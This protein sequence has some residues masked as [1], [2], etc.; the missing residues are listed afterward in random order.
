[1]DL[2]TIQPP[3][4]SPSAQLDLNVQ[5]NAVQ[6]QI[7]RLPV[8]ATLV[9]TV[10]GNDKNGNLIVRMAG[11]DLI[12]SSPLAISKGAQVALKIDNVSGS[13]TA[14]LL[15]I[16]GKL[17]A[18]QPQAISN[19]LQQNPNALLKENTPEA[20]KR[21]FENPTSLKIVGVLNQGTAKIAQPQANV[22]QTNTAVVAKSDIV[23]L[24]SPQTTAVKAIM[25]TATPEIVQGL[26]ASIAMNDTKPAKSELVDSLPEE[27]KP[28]TV[29]N[30]KITKAANPE[31]QVV[32]GDNRA[33][34]GQEWMKEQ[35]KVAGKE[36]ANPNPSTSLNVNLKASAE[37]TKSATPEINTKLAALAAS[38]PDNKQQMANNLQQL[39]Q[40]FA[41]SFKPLPNGNILL[42]AIVIDT[43]PD[44][45]LLVETRF[46]KMIVDAGSQYNNIQKGAVLDLEI[47]SFMQSP[48]AEMKLPE[49]EMT[50]QNL[51]K[52]WPAL[53]ELIEHSQIQQNNTNLPNKLAG[54]DSLFA[55]RMAAFMNAIK[56]G[57]LREWLGRSNYDALEADDIGSTLLGKIK[58]DLGTI[59]DL[60]QNIDASKW[61]TMLFPIY[62]GRELHQA[63]MHVK[64]LPDEN[65]KP[66]KSVGTRFIVELD[67]GHF[68]EIQMDGLVHNNVASKYF[69]MIIR[70]HK[71]FDHETEMDI[72]K[73][74]SDA[75]E[76]T[77]FK[78]D[79]EFATMKEF[80]VKV[81]DSLIEKK[82]NKSIDHKGIEA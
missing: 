20:L 7:Q 46:G 67:T 28:G 32:Q 36:A 18:T 23:S 4:P 64:Y 26:K 34:P 29:A 61:Q 19:Q 16:D 82:L 58:G 25:V 68:G 3:P 41:A 13:F 57:D 37:T 52:T 31:Q 17:P 38:L 2:T 14:T 12:L 72:R 76:I 59:R 21:A 47:M 54:I 39:V 48:K 60:S 5:N 51:A 69:D 1:M 71:P 66:D 63:R 78:G 30:L 33:L 40:N 6:Q 79:I 77:G 42:N 43:K 11:N 49:E 50:L 74:F 8:G 65:N 55:G 53:K 81:F 22:P 15:S 56:S 27:I 35:N 73:I 44:G 10:M 80:P 45:E 62:D 70:T 9:G 24:T 75:G